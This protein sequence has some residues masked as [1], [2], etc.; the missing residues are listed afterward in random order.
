MKRSIRKTI[1]VLCLALAAALSCFAPLAPKAHA[2]TTEEIEEL[3]KKRD[4]IS[5]ERAEKQAVVDKLEEEQASIFERKKALDQRNTLTIEQMEL[6]EQQIRLYDAIIAEEAQKLQDAVDLENDQLARYHARIRSMEESGDYNILALILR[7]NSLSELLTSID[8]MTEIMES[9][10]QLEAQYVAAREHREEVKAKYEDVKAEFEAK[11]SELAEEQETLQAELDE[12]CEL[13]EKL[14]EDIESHA[15]ELAELQAAEDEADA[16]VNKLIAEL[17]A[18]RRAEEEERRRR[19]E[20]Q[21]RQQPSGGGGGGGS[22][23]GGST[24]GTGAFIWPC[25]SCYYITSRQGPRTH[26]ITGEYKNHSGTDIGASYGATVIAADSGTVSLAGENG[27]YGNCVMINHGNGYYTLYGHLSSIAV[28]WGQSVRQG[29]VIGYVGSTGNSTGP[30]LH[31]EIRSG[32]TKLDPETFF[33][34][35]FSYA[36]DA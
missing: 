16:A 21:R 24:T 1:L 34:G 2:V 6:N 9:D 15:E 31:F 27:G 30:H 20:E 7:A 13:I 29:D 26:P 23:S 19:E 25:P 11:L 8:D 28:S 4:A 35:G 14:K 33:S 12:A 32:D 3:K 5:A 36:P 22:S 18:Q 10:K 17:E